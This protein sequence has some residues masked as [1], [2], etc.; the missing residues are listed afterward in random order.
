MCLSPVPPSS[1]V[2][3]LLPVADDV[4]FV[5]RHDQFCLR[6]KRQRNASQLEGRRIPAIAHRRCTD[7]KAQAATRPNKVGRASAVR[8]NGAE[9]TDGA[10]DPRSAHNTQTPVK[11]LMPRTPVPTLSHVLSP[12]TPE[13]TPFMRSPMTVWG[14]CCWRGS[15]NK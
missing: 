11:A 7:S 5:L 3:M 6:S 1:T 8:H 2:S 13:Q 4:L 10:L 14:V 12:H 9:Q 15:C